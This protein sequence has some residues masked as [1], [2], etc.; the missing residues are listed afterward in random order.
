ML[1][2]LS[3]SNFKKINISIQNSMIDFNTVNTY[4][5][6]CNKNIHAECLKH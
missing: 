4:N 1:F 3:T 5:F 6:L 2:L